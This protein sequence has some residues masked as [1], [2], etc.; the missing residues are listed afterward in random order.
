MTKVFFCCCQLAKLKNVQG[1]HLY[2]TLLWSICYNQ[3]DA[4]FHGCRVVGYVDF[5]F[6]YKIL[7]YE[8]R[9]HGVPIHE[10]KNK[11]QNE[12]QHNYPHPL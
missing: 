4:C 5:N 6:Q 10:T 3:T 8:T 12:K 9:A 2:D 1:V 11:V 7:L